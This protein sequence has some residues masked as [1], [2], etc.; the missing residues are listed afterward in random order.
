M[1]DENDFLQWQVGGGINRIRRTIHSIVSNLLPPAQKWWLF[2]TT[3]SEDNEEFCR[4]DNCDLLLRE[5]VRIF[6]H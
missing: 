6:G 4:H 5:C 2:A 1:S 3:D